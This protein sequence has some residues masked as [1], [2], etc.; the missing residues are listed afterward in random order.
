MEKLIL[1]D[2]TEIEIEPGTGI[3][4]MITYVEDYAALGDLAEK[5]TRDNL[6]EVKNEA[7]NGSGTTI[8]KNMEL[9]EPNFKVTKQEQRLKIMFGL[10]YLT[11]DEI[12][13]PIIN[14]AI[15]YLTDEQALIVKT[16][17]SA[18][19][20]GKL[21]EEGRRV[22]YNGLLF[23]CRQ[24]HTSQ[25]GSEPGV[26]PS[27]WVALESGAEAGTLEDPIPV[28]ETISIS[29]ME[30]EYGKYYKEGNSVYLCKRGG[31]TDEQAEA[32]YGQKEILS[33]PPSDLVGQY[34]ELVTI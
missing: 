11:E 12:K 31:I 9:A 2:S 23:K 16:L 29:G 34:F 17:Y 6:S 32:M 25:E 28:P 7:E 5:L 8:Y 18:Y 10:R 3:S 14:T 4:R 1:K 21:Y 20:Y 30:Y 15:E 26:A 19:E 27:L 33:F 22:L 24:K 13:E